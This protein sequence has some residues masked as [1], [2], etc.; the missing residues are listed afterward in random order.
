MKNFIIILFL[1]LCMTVLFSCFATDDD[2]LSARRDT[3][4]E[5]ID[6]PIVEKSDAENQIVND[7]PVTDNPIISSTPLV[8]MIKIEQGTFMMGLDKDEPSCS[9]NCH[10]DPTCST[11]YLYA[12]QHKVTLTRSFFMGKYPITLGQ[13][14]EVMGYRTTRHNIY[15]NAYNLSRQTPHEKHPV[16]LITWYEAIEFCNKLSIQEGLEP[17]YIITEK[18]FY[19]SDLYSADVIWNKEANGY[20]LPTEAEWEYACRAGTTTRFNTGDTITEEQAY[21][22]GGVAPATVG[23]YKPNAWGLYDMHGN[24]EEWCWDWYGGYNTEGRDVIAVLYETEKEFHSLLEAVVGRYID[25]LNYSELTYENNQK[26]LSYYKVNDINEIRNVVLNKRI[27]SWQLKE[28]IDPTG[29]STGFFRTAR[30]GRHLL[31]KSYLHMRSGDRAVN[32]LTNL[33]P[34]LYSFDIGFRIV[35]NAE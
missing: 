25:R 2:T 35:R 33:T 32:R 13:F 30:G 6:K 9:V 28:R 8:E 1:S 27:S 26:I 15:H 11:V 34:E 20:R 7:K 4:K 23:S 19:D 16:T 10:G 31:E 29:P 24:V 5:N 22:G 14:R 12:P 3:D 17:V 21:M 18:K